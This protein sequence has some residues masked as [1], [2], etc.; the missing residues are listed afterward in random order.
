MGK[1]RRQ[2]KKFNKLKES[3][4]N[5]DV[6]SKLE[7]FSANSKEILK[8]IKL[9]MTIKRQNKKLDEKLRDLKRDL[10]E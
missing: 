1:T 4:H 6:R 8:G 2:K 10:N 3:I 7:R 9:A 5:L